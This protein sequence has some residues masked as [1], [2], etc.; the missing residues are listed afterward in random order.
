MLVQARWPDPKRP[1]E[2]AADAPSWSSIFEKGKAWSGLTN[3]WH[4][5]DQKKSGTGGTN[6]W[7]KGSGNG[8]KENGYVDAWIT[9]GGGLV[10]DSAPRI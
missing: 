10:R 6:D 3:G 4:G 9:D 8:W 7:K 2:G 5:E 1:F